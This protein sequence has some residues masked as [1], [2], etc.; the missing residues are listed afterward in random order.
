MSV[1][2]GQDKVGVAYCN[3]ANTYK[4]D[5][6]IMQETVYTPWTRPEDWPDL[7][8]LNLEMSGT[9]SFIY[10]TYRTGHT[11][12]IFAC[13]W[14]LVSGQ[15][16]TIATGYIE[17][18]QF[19]P[20]SNGTDTYTTNSTLGL[21]FDSYEEG[22]IVI[23]VTGRFNKF[24][25]KDIT[26]PDGGTSKYYMQPMLERI[27]YVPEL[28]YF[29]DGSS[30]GSTGNGTVTLQRDKINNGTGNTLTTM[31]SAWNYCYNLQSL[32]ISG[33]KTQNVQYMSYAFGNCKKLEVLDVSNLDMAK[34]VSMS[35]MFYDCEKIKTL[36][37]RN[38]NCEKLTGGG[39]TYAFASCYALN[40]IKGL[41]NIYTNNVTSLQGLFQYCYSLKD[42][43]GIAGWNTD[44]VTNLASLFYCCYNI[45][46]ID[47]SAW[48]V[49]KVTS[50]SSMFASCR[51]VKYIKFPQTRTASLTGSL[52]YIFQACNN[53]QEV[54]LSWF[55]PVT[56]AV[57]SLANMFT[58]CR[59][60]TEINIPEGW[61]I[62]GCTASESCYR[63][64]SE[65]Y[66]LQKITG[67]SNWDMSNYNG[68]FAYAFQ[69]DYCLK[70]LDIKNWCPHP[71]SMYYAFSEC[72][73]L[74]EIDLTGWHW[75]N[76]TS[77]ALGST[78]SNCPSLK[79]IK[80]IEHMGDSGNITSFSSCFNGC[81][82]LTS[83]PDISSWDPAKV[84]SCGNMFASCCSL[85]SLTI[86]NWSLPKCTSVTNMFR[87][88]Y[89][90]RELDLSGWSLP[91]LTSDGDYI[92]CDMTSLEKCSGLPIGRM[93]RYRGDYCLPEDQWARIF[94]QLP[95]VSNK[96][97]YMNTVNINRLSATTKAIA[98]GK[99]WT[100][101]D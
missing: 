12:D 6:S 36:D 69:M 27:W 48:N 22:Y 60:L 7:D 56:S 45:G 81:Q 14:Q 15:S 71:T 47:L 65:C 19:V 39:L 25:L 64:F 38:W 62:T 28:F 58:S 37:L 88:C 87:Y 8:S 72:L 78:F 94:T 20:Y 26:R 17:N 40:E 63:V 76:M 10:M 35:Y 24:Y 50:I 95:S 46:L 1:Y 96:T 32:D 91:A 86:K 31:Y 98:T 54:D 90:M 55:G 79:A 97:I 84:T 11:D 100:L 75:E 53:L 82:S 2:L 68:S 66:M 16:I 59:S 29:Y 67:I 9:E 43:S 57:T 21:S 30:T 52:A 89:K 51:T 85:E 49:G 101:A 41:D 93:H 61:D 77:T 42:V 73:S 74:E 23:K 44:K 70:E 99:G 13:G 5:T 92:F 18:G 33:L 34:V 3:Q 4:Y 83:L 80:G